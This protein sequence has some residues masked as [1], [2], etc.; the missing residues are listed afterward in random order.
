MRDHVAERQRYFDLEAERQKIA[1]AQDLDREKFLSLYGDGVP[2][3]YPYAD[4]NP[5]FYL[6]TSY[7]Q[8]EDGWKV[9]WRVETV[10]DM[11]GEDRRIKLLGAGCG[12]E[13]TLLHAV[14]NKFPTI[15]LFGIDQIPFPEFVG[16][17]KVAYYQG[18]IFDM[19]KYFPDQ[20]FDIVVC[21]E[22]LEHIPPTRV[23]EAWAE[24]NRILKPGG[25]IILTVPYTENLI[26]FS[27]FC[28]VCNQWVTES[29][30]IRCYPP[31]VVTAEMVVNGFKCV[32]RR[33]LDESVRA[34]RGVKL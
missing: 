14:S 34:Y 8:K 22:V 16:P 3:L 29:G 17:E 20:M 4:V 1:N 19:R 32:E 25:T 5:K 27:L 9:K 23:M 18:T 6:K 28:P 7:S 33:R 12:W 13:G 21:M 30:H 11:I 10:M 24:F 26:G 15:S 31:S 2:E